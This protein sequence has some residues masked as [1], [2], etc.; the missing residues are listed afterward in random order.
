MVTY[1]AL[2]MKSV[3]YVLDDRKAFKKFLLDGRIEMHNNAVES[4]FRPLLWADVIGLTPAAMMR[5]R[6]L[7]SCTLCMRA[8]R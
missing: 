6:I 7:P 4:V 8:V 2:V 3:N 1:G 5:H